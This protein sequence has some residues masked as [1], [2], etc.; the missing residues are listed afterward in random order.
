MRRTFGV[1]ELQGIEGLQE[2]FSFTKG[3]KTM[4]IKGRAWAGDASRGKTLLFDLESD[5]KQLNPIA[6]TAVEDKMCRH[7]VRLM[8]ENDAPQEQFARLGLEKFI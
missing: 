6:D 5:P 4:R 1:D 3:C 7:I 8:K 2:P